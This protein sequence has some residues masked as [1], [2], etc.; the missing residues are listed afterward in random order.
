MESSK[1]LGLRW[2]HCMLGNAYGTIPR[3]IGQEAE[4]LRVYVLGP[5]S[6]DYFSAL[7]LGESPKSERKRRYPLA[8]RSRSGIPCGIRYRVFRKGILF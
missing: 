4:L 1:K 3:V 5:S 6:V 7:A 2:H 8:L